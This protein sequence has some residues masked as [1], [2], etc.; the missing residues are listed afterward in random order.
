M[1]KVLASYLEKQKSFIP[2]SLPL[3]ATLNFLKI[4]GPIQRPTNKIM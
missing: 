2:N 4:D 3:P 1:I